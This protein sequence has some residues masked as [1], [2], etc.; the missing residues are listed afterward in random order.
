MNRVVSLTVLFVCCLLSFTCGTF[1]RKSKLDNGRIVGG[2]VVDIKD[3]PY[4]VSLRNLGSH[5][6]GGSIISDRFILTAGHCTYSK[7]QLFLRIRA[8]STDKSKGGVT[9]SIKRI[10]SHPKFDYSNID[11]DFAL[12]EVKGKIRYNKNVGP[13]KLPA[14]DQEIIDGINC[15][16]S[17]WGE[18]KV[19]LLNSSII[20]LPL[21]IG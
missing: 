19:S 20:M 18:T 10:I 3:F 1:V 11:Y 8:G 13:I 6:C 17:G 9:Y 5:M 16:V 12:I 2:K 7:I 15:T 14:Q 4:Q 21:T